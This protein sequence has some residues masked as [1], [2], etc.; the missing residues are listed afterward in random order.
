MLKVANSS[1][2]TFLSIGVK[3]STQQHQSRCITKKGA[4]PMNTFRFKQIVIRCLIVCAAVATWHGP[5]MATPIDFKDW[6]SAFINGVYT[7]SNSS[8]AGTI[9]G[10]SGPGFFPQQGTFGVPTVITPQIFTS[11]FQIQGINGLGSSVNFNFS[12][13]YKWGT[14]GQLILGNI[15]N[16]YEYALEAWDFSGTPIDVNLWTTPVGLL[17]EYPSTTPGTLGYFSTSTTGRTGA[18]FASIF[19]VFDPL[20]DADGGQGGVLVLGGLMDVGR[21]ELSLTA[22]DLAP[23]AQQ[24]DLILFNVGTPAAVPEPSS[25]LLLGT[26]L[27]GLLG[28][29]WRKRWGNSDS[30]RSKG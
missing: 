14:G 18:G 24:V 9:S 7:F 30:F 21:I 20:A 16:Y 28:Y 25:L 27:M 19:S 22:S 3:R 4:G 26:G 13:G 11:E 5:A 29:G 12:P 6:G 1:L 10:A 15:H 8:N 23:N 17:T 2:R